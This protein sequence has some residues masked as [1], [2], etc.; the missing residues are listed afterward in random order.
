MRLLQQPPEQNGAELPPPARPKAATAGPM[1]TGEQTAT[2]AA[3]LPPAED[4]EDFHVPSAE[5]IRQATLAAVYPPCEDQPKNAA[6][7]CQHNANQQACRLEN[8]ACASQIS[9]QRAH[10]R[11]DERFMACRLAKEKRE[12][13]RSAHL[14]PDYIP[15]GGAAGLANLES[16]LK[17]EGSIQPTEAAPGASDS[18]DDNPHHRM[19]F[20]G[21]QRNG[22][23]RS[24]VLSALAEEPQVRS[25]ASRP[26]ITSHAWPEPRLPHSKLAEAWQ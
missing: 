17:P 2:A 16:R 25:F 12:R 7:Y 4:D 8:Y 1:A 9:S 26:A 15:L 6:V 14:A 13:L 24:G 5:M 10:R 3:P 20:V 21:D 18:D 23:A 11:R 22:T 19:T